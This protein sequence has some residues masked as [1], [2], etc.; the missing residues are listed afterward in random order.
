M[1]KVAK[2]SKSKNVKK[3]SAKKKAPRKA[4][5]VLDLP[6]AIEERL[7]EGRAE[8]ETR[9]RR[10]ARRAGTGRRTRPAGPGE[11]LE[12][13]ARDPVPS[14]AD[15]LRAHVVSPFTFYRGGGAGHGGDL[16]TDATTGL[17][18]QLAA[19]PTCRTSACSAR[20]SA[21]WSSTSTTSTRRCPVRSSG[22]SSAWRRASRSRAATAA[23][24]QG[25]RARS[26]RGRGPTARRWREFAGMGNLEVW[27]ARLDIDDASRRCRAGDVTAKSSAAGRASPRR[28][29]GRA[30]GARAS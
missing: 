13:Q 15:P 26:C 12:G 18:A 9:A 27:Y 14:C 4:R 16:A 17:R 6:K 23:S 8:R 21:A 19:T 3:K 10:G 24:P 28:A 5:T 1:A 7:A 22:T 20:R 29:P 25:A 30:A 2:S 11:L